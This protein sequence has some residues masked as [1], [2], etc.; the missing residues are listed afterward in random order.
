MPGSI[1]AAEKTHRPSGQPLSTP[2]AKP[3]LQTFLRQRSMRSLVTKPIANADGSPGVIPFPRSKKLQNLPL[4][5]TL[6]SARR[7][8]SIFRPLHRH[9]K[10]RWLNPYHPLERPKWQTLLYHTHF[11]RLRLLPIDLNSP[12]SKGRYCP[13][14]LERWL[15]G[16]RH[17]PAKDAYPLKGTVGSN[18]SLS[19]ILSLEL[20]FRICSRYF[21]ITC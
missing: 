5:T 4:A 16:R 12:F 14:S 21:S 17:V 2:F 18:P 7:P 6:P 20:R 9:T 3:R 10:P 11:H 1:A 13:L 19:D 8:M 15:S